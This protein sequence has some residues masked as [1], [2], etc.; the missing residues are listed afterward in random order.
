MHIAFLTNEYPPLP[1]G[2]IGTNVK[3]LA[4]AL[5]H[6]GHRVTVVGW[7]KADK[8]EDGGVNIT[9]LPE[10]SIP[11]IGWFANRR[12]VEKYLRHLVKHEG[13]AIVEAADWGG[14]SKG[15]RPGCPLVI[16]CNGT[17]TYFGHLL[18]ERVRW[19]LWIEERGGLRQSDAICAVSQFTADLTKQLFGLHQEIP[20][21]PNCIDVT[22]FRP[23]SRTEIDP[24]LILNVGTLN[25]KK[26]VLDLC[27][28]FNLLVEQNPHARLA[29]VGR[30]AG[31]KKTRSSSTRELCVKTLTPQASARVH[32]LGA[33]PHEKIQ[34]H[35]RRAA[36]C[37]FPSYAEALP[38][39][40]L[41]ASACAKPIVA[42]D[43]GW[44]SEIIDHGA[45]GMLVKPGDH[46]SFVRITQTL[47]DDMDQACE[48]GDAAR[49]RVEQIFS[50]SVVAR[51]SLRWYQ[52]VL[53]ARS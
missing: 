7:G 8:W 36:V 10:T 16:R 32:F 27:Q 52:E 24:N 40:W 47:L 42:Y 41:E 38:L 44:A 13:L 45:T 14:M 49:H 25:R 31:D 19:R 6:A 1:H 2:G 33:Q 5:V 18:N 51:Q 34:E 15:I 28:I 50:S 26:G 17:D 11:K 46:G 9:M 39:T 20:V 29:F 12:I 37:V 22:K 30:D 3:T 43:I 48:M 35:I 53:N 4:Q 21:I 23:A